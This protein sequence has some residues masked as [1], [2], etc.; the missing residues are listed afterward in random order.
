[1]SGP[2]RSQSNTKVRFFFVRFVSLVDFPTAPPCSILF[3]TRRLRASGAQLLSPS[4]PFFFAKSVR[5]LT[6]SA[7]W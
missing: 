4:L 6:S 3:G 1:M 7:F 5:T 2:R